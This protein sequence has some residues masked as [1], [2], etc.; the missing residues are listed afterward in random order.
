L[1][2]YYIAERKYI[3]DDNVLRYIYNK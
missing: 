2:A 1:Y 3:D